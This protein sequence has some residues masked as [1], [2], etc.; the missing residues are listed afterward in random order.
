MAVENDERWAAFCLLEKFKRLLNTLDVI[1][2][3]DTQDVPSIGNESRLNVF[4]KGNAG[5]SL[6]RDVIVVVDPAKI[7]ETEVSGEGRGLRG[8]ALHHAAIAAN[9]VNVVIKNF[10]ARPI[11]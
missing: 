6:D 9:R 5:V 11:K 8:D 4:S 7:V 10:E 2:I 3:A 1:R